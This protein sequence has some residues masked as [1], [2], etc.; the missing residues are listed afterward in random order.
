MT[1][2]IDKEFAFDYGHRVWTQRLDDKDYS[3]DDACVCRHLH[4]H[5]A[6]VQVFL[7]GEHL[8][9]QGMVVDFKNLGWAKR[10]F[11]LHVDHKFILDESDPLY[12]ILTLNWPYRRPVVIGDTH[13]GYSFVTDGADRASDGPF[14]ELL[15]GFL[16]VDFVPTSENL[17]RWVH[18]I[19]QEKMLKI[20]VRC[21][22]VDWWETPKSRSSY[23]EGY[24]G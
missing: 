18:G 8:N 12:S 20:G 19:I 17:S 13:A 6:K 22:R 10:D 1:F 4:G 14:K 11:D 5:R 15:D 23:R 24:R 9:E 21:T 16:V 2:L 3:V 7:E